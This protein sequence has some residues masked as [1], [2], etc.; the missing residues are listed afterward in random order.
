MPPRIA[1]DPHA[2]EA[3]C[4][5]W[6]IQELELFGSVLRDDFRPDSDVD[7]L[8]SF[9]DDRKPTLPMLSNIQQELESLLGRRVDLVERQ[10]I[11]RS[12]NYI[13]RDHILRHR[14]PLYVAR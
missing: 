6:S 2:L 14:E 7:V 13:L 8:V 1:I 9:A 12:E 11:E 10:S 5:G 3:F 4:R